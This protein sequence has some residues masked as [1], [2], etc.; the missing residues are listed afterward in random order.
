METWELPMAALTRR[1][2]GWLRFWAWVLYLAG[3]LM[4]GLVYATKTFI[5]TTA[6]GWLQPVAWLVTGAFGIWGP[7]TCGAAGASYVLARLQGRKLGEDVLAFTIL[8]G[9][10]L[11]C[12]YFVLAL[13]AQFIASLAVA[14]FS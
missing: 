3:P 9:V 14:M 4:A 12:S 6:P 13:V 8:F 7:L 11:V 5:L 1:E 10:V 2:R